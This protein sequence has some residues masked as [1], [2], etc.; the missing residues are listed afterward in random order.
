MALVHV[1]RF[2]SSLLV[3]VCLA[4][5]T[6]GAFAQQKTMTIYIPWGVE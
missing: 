4:F 5:L 1:S 6:G 2:R 3:L